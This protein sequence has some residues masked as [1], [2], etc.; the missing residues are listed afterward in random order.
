MNF[1][2][3][4]TLKNLSSSPSRFTLFILV[5]EMTVAGEELALGEPAPVPVAVVHHS[6]VLNGRHPHLSS[7]KMV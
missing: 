4:K 3:K 6:P 5:K 7:S 1:I 2:Y